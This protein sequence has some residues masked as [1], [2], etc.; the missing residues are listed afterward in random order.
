VTANATSFADGNTARLKFDDELAE[1][2]L[3]ALRAG[4]YI[5]TAAN[6][7]GV[8]RA[9]FYHWMKQ[10]RSGVEPYAKFAAD[11]DQALATAELTDWAFVGKAREKEWAAA[12]WRLERRHPERYGRRTRVDSNV[13]VTATPFL[14]Y[15]KYTPEQLRTLVELLRIGTPSPDDPALGTDGRPALELMPGEIVDGELL[16]EEEGE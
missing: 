16:A 11:V 10:G 5:E 9:I 12:A 15:S 8:S 2:I 4:A 6:H 7:A 3:T 1:R 14:D 13:N